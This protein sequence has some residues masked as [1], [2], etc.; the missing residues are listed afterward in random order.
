MSAET[1]AKLSPVE[2]AQRQL[3]AYNAR[4]LEGFLAVYA[5]D[6]KVYRPPAAEPVMSGKA[7]MAEFYGSQRF[8]L[9]GLH[10]EV[11]NRMAFGNKVIDH[12]RI[13]GI[14]PQP[15][16]VAAVYEVVDGAIRTVWFIGA[17]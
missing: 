12:E 3:E 1:A 4:D 16:E 8:N 10:A 7:Q 17:E 5:D 2:A 9:P 6:V 11:V 13:T 15:F 14:R